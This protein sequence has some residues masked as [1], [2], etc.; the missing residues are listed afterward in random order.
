MLSESVFM[1]QVTTFDF[2]FIRNTKFGNQ[3]Y[4]FW[5]YRIFCYSEEM[6]V[7]VLY[8]KTIGYY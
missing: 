5:K 1:L 2:F 8:G 4:K 3:A 6:L 7:M